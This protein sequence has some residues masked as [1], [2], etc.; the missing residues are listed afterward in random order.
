MNEDLIQSLVDQR[1]GQLLGER[2]KASGTG[3]GVAPTGEHALFNT[4]GT[5]PGIVSTIVR[6]DGIE[7]YLENG[8]HIRKSMYL[9]PIFAIMTGQTGSTGTEPTAP[10]DENVPVAGD[11]KLC[12]QTWTF[13]EMTM[14][15]KPVRI[16]NLGE[17]V[18]RSSPI[19]LKL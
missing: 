16:D 5:E 18:N 2:L 12:N 15:S 17:L 7:D 6:P 13:G 4:P 9:N 14:K 3:I 1:V 10:C 11:L 8:G 19:D